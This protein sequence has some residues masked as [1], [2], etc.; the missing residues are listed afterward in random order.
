[1]ANHRLNT[2]FT[3]VPRFP[4][5]TLRFFVGALR[6][7]VLVRHR[8]LITKNNK[9]RAQEGASLISL[10]LPGQDDKESGLC[11]DAFKNSS[12]SPFQLTTVLAPVSQQG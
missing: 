7:T 2:G 9:G 8:T 12:N 1:M 11:P 5:Y 6:S 4:D 10:V 3:A